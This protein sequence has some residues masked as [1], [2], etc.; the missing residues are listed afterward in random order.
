MKL[1][2]MIQKFE[3]ETITPITDDSDETELTEAAIKKMRE[4]IL[5]EYSSTLPNGKVVN[6]ELDVKIVEV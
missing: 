3:V 2:K 6:Y 1:L 5:A 4:E